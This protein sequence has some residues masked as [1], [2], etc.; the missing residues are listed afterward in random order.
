MT[1]EGGKLLPIRGKIEK[2]VAE[3]EYLGVTLPEGS[4]GSDRMES[5]IRKA[6]QRLSV[7][8][9]RRKGTYSRWTKR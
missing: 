8:M 9:R 7:I 1:S 6:N 5:R 2:E 4:F 3:M